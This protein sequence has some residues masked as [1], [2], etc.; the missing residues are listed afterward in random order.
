MLPAKF[1]KPQSARFKFDCEPLNFLPTSSRSNPDFL[2][3]AHMSSPSKTPRSEQGN[4]SPISRPICSPISKIRLLT[5]RL[6]VA[7]A[8]VQIT[9]RISLDLRQKSGLDLAGHVVI[10]KQTAG[11]LSKGSA[12]VPANPMKTAQPS[13]TAATARTCNSTTGLLIL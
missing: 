8:L 5:E 12:S 3:F 4:F 6:P 1:H 2:F 11:T 13:L 10:Y 7:P 9:N